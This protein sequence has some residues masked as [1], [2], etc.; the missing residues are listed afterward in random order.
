MALTLVATSWTATASLSATSAAAAENPPLWQSISGCGA[1]VPI[2]TIQATPSDYLS[3]LSQLVAGDR[4]QLAAGTYTQGLSIHGKSGGPDKCIIVEG[5]AS[6]SPAVF[7]NSNV[8][9]I[10]SLKDSSYI[11]V[12]NLSL[13]GGGLGGDGV[14]GEAHG[15]SNHHILLEG[16]NLK[17][18]DVDP[19]VSGI[20]SK[21]WAWNWVV[22]NNTIASTG[23]GMYFGHSDGT[24]GTANFLV[25][26]NVV[27][28]TRE[29]N[30]QF[31]HQT[32][33]NTSIGMPSTG[34]TIIRNNVLSKATRPL[35]GA[36]RAMPNLL[37]GHWPTSGPGSTDTYQI[38]GNVLYDNPHEGLFQGE[39][40]L[41][42]HDNLLVN[43][44][45]WG[46]SIQ[47]HNDVPK[48]IDIFNNTVVTAAEGIYIREPDLN[49]PQRV[50][51]N[52]VF[53]P[54][55]LTGGQQSNN[56]TGSYSA[57]ST[58]LTNPMAALGA[59]L[60]L[61][62]KTGQLQGTAI[63]YSAHTGLIDYDRDFNYRPRIA[64]YRGAYSGDGV[65]P[66]WKPALAIKPEPAPAPPPNPTPEPIGSGC[67]AL[68]PLRTI[69][70]NPSNY[71]SLMVG[72]IP[73]DRLQ[74]AAGTYTQG[75]PISGMNGQADKCIVFEGPASGS[76]AVFL[77][78]DGSNVVSFRNS[79]YIAVRNLT[80]D[81]RG[82][83]SDGV[84]AEYGSASVHHILLEGLS[85]RN[86]NATGISG[87]TSTAPVWNWV[88]RNNTIT[89]AYSGMSFGTD[90]THTMANFLVENNLIYDTRAYN[91]R[92]G[93]QLSR[94]TSIGMPSTGT[95]IIRNNVF[96]KET[97]SLS[98]ASATPNLRMGH[99][100]LS[101][102]G[103]SD[104]YQVYGNLFY[105]NPYEALFQGEGNIALHDNLFVNRTQLAVNI[106]AN[107][108]APRRIDAYNNTVVSSTT[109]IRVTGADPA[110]SQRVVGNAVFAATPLSG[111][112]QSNNV[113]GSYSA[114]STYLN[115]PMAALGGGLNLY[116]KT[117]QLQ[118]AAIDYSA[119][120]GLTDY[121]RDFN[122]RSRITTYRGAYSGDGVNPGWTLAWAIKSQ[123]GPAPSN[124]LQN[125]VAVTGLSGATG[126]QRFW[127]M[128][129]PPGASNLKFQTS[130]GT[131]DGDPYVR[132]GSAPTTA[133]YDCGPVTGDNNET[134]TFRAPAPGTWH[135]MVD[136]YAAYSGMTL[137]GSYQMS[138]SC[139][140][141]TEV[142]PNDSTA[143][144]QAISGAC[145]Q[146]A[147]TFVNET[148]ANDYFRLSLPAGRTVTAQLYGLS[149][150]YDLYLY[151]VAGTLLAS[152]GN[153]EA[154]ADQAS[155]TNTGTTAVNV[156][157]RVDR[158][159]S[160]Q[161]PYQLGISY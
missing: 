140:S 142:E 88:V 117:G 91:L 134:C 96:S 75:L 46:V 101:G 2:K 83:N 32:A 25:E 45:Q 4:L 52:A 130:G 9:N 63:D 154:S 137:I 61:Y 136:G 28:D 111:G 33:R 147:G 119:F 128:T 149:V 90:G 122:N 55:P 133:A 126:S 50:F 65:N 100:P 47:R 160:T 150:D 12:R 132:L 138:P 141:V 157:V 118:G 26:N 73:G 87:I 82:L 66:G 3:K 116:P 144:P 102:A 107:D 153:S 44:T 8:R 70:A 99:W 13:D 85:L 76:P 69:Q 81:G 80:L 54:T 27:S 1:L 135:V 112:Q 36:D 94:D 145:S 16:L 92:F 31:K 156:F 42:F 115:N 49:Y 29:Y 106:Q 15:T 110:Y 38:Y 152:S 58:Y 93:R 64:T 48:R 95:T 68:T 57:A 14:R 124:Q 89:S 24:Y 123:S 121:D 5:P 98:G 109:G 84:K 62:P 37:V 79:S 71:R 161:T 11:A 131:G 67:G 105:Q 120:T 30:V 125:G 23:T 104:I 43:R 60:D 53:S 74:L 21:S 10:V 41:A 139:T 151:N 113:T 35:S 146:I 18:F 86:F 159:S 20:N 103:S 114:A 78:N 108:S 6:G 22:R 40:N 143:A 127:T 51:G 155:W 77:A 59:G 129:V 158:Y 7:T 39:G 34:T 19:L 56:V 72:L 17:N 148:T 97:G